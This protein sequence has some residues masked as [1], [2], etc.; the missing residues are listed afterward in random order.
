MEESTMT[1]SGTTVGTLSYMS[2]EQIKGQAIDGRSDIF[3]LGIILYQLLT[4]KMPFLGDNIS[5]IVYKIVNEQPQRM[6]EIN[7]DLPPGYD[8]VVQKVL[9]KNPSDRFQT[10]RG[11]RRLLGRRRKD[12]RE[13]ARLRYRTKGTM[14]R[15]SSVKKSL[16]AALALSGIAV[17]A[18]S[19][20][21]PVTQIRQDR[22][23]NRKT[24]A[25]GT[26][27][28]AAKTGP[29]L[30]LLRPK[31]NSRAEAGEGRSLGGGSSSN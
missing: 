10:C 7:Q 14:R 15:P 23:P 21:S 8:L 12:S 25:V 24:A 22:R 28:P 27:D 4:G 5:T 11:S 9:A 6:T 3:A 30:V 18:G 29:V 2:P 19:D 16:I 17:V 20:L 31:G 13:D 1:Q 26:S